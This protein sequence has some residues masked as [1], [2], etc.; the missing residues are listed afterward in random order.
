MRSFSCAVVFPAFYSLYIIS[1]H[2]LTA[3][4]EEVPF[5]STGCSYTSDYCNSSCVQELSANF[6]IPLVAVNCTAKNLT[7][8][9]TDLPINTGKLALNFNSIPRLSVDEIKK[10]RYLKELMIE[11]NSMAFIRDGTFQSNIMLQRLNMGGNKL[12]DLT[13]GI[14]KGLKNLLE[15]YLHRNRISRLKNGTFENLISLINLDLSENHILVI[16]KGAFTGLQ[17]LTYLNLSGNKL[18]KVFQVHFSELTSL[19]ALNL[20]FNE[21]SSLESESFSNFLHLKTLNLSH[22]NLTFIP[23]EVF[24]PLKGLGSLDL[25]N[26]PIEFIPLEVF[27]SLRALKFVNLSFSSVRVF[28]GAYLETISPHLKIYVRHNPL[29]CTCDMRWLKEWLHGNTYQNST[30]LNSSE[31]RCKYPK[32]LSG[33]SLLSL[34]IADLSCSCEY[35]QRS[36]MCVS[37]GKTCNCANKWALP[38]CSDTCQFNDTSRIVPY[39]IMCSYSQGK[40]FCSNMSELCVDNA[41]LTYSNLSSQCTCKTGYQGSGFLKCTDVDECVHARNV[42]HSD[43][44]CINTVGSYRCV[45]LDGYHG[46]GVICHSVKHRRTVAIVTTA[47]SVVIFVA[48]ISMLIFCVAPKR[49][50]QIKDAKKST[51]RR[52]KKKQSTRRYVDL[53][54]IHELGFTNTACTQGKK[55]LY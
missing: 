19:T 35:C 17:H 47:L 29:D 12:H 40:C 21:I 55:E 13:S 20:G 16:D 31:V 28:H 10:I 44:D 15:L 49:I 39:E 50:Q 5:H 8:F 41:Y 2:L 45:C 37:G 18:G 27:S 23:K 22:N 33:R 43:A 7:E 25:S 53:Y 11:G 6:D 34:N 30:F 42:C 24:R 46:D 36:S 54:K 14:F 3:H 4:E 48:L 52:R 9:P 1:Q 51:E 38:S 32:T 26:N